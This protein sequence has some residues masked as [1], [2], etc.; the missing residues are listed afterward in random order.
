MRA[1]NFNVG[2]PRRPWAILLGVLLADATLCMFASHDPTR[3]VVSEVVPQD[4]TTEE[5]IN[6]RMTRG[7]FVSNPV[8]KE[9]K[10]PSIPGFDARN[11]PGVGVNPD[12][13]EGPTAR[14][15]S[16]V[17]VIPDRLRAGYKSIELRD[18]MALTY[19]FSS[20][21]LRSQQ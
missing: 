7:K 16:G 20:G 9:W 12:G 4:P 17:I 8:S 19:T 21:T 18:R 14:P 13:T 1:V 2:I 5:S 15:D 10:R 6:V 3:R 11:S